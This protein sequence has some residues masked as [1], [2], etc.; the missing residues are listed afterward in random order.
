M[1]FEKM[2]MPFSGS[3][4]GLIVFTHTVI[5]RI[6]TCWTLLLHSGITIKLAIYPC[7]CMLSKGKKETLSA[8]WNGRWSFL[9]NELS[10]C[11]RVTWT[12]HSNGTV[13]VSFVTIVV[14]KRNA[15]FRKSKLSTIWPGKQIRFRDEV[16]R[17]LDLWCF[18]IFWCMYLML[19][20]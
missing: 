10:V 11:P 7:D 2:N 1:T 6:F 4:Q 19:I 20:G 15:T 3:P 18:Q 12:Q 9:I 5:A 17:D 16:T 8:T 14:F 13:L